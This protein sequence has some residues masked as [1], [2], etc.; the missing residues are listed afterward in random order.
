[1]E[2]VRELDTESTRAILSGLAVQQR[3]QQTALSDLARL[4][5]EASAEIDR[6]IAFL[7]ASDPYAATELEDQA[8]DH[9]IDGDELEP[10]F[11]GITAGRGAHADQP[12]PDSHGDELEADYAD[13]TTTDDE[14]SLGSVAASEHV[15]QA[16]WSQGGSSDLEDEHDGREPS[17][18]DEPSIGYDACTIIAEIDT[19]ELEPSLGWTVDGCTNVDLRNTLPLDDLE[20]GA[21]ARAPQGRADLEEATVW[22]EHSHRRFLNGLSR[23]QRRQVVDKRAGRRDI[24]SSVI[25]A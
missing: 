9:P 2:N 20:E 14:P 15:S 5:K 25:V 12:W 18:D 19:G 1:M 24:D 13:G 11:C 7:D 8:D 23:Q 22:V 4:R 6:L 10:S 21:P 16:S 17:E 3:G